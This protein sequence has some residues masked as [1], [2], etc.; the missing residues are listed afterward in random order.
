MSEINMSVIW[1]VTN[2]CP[3]NCS[4]CVM[5]AGLHCDKK[6]LSLKEKLKVCQHIDL[7]GVRV[8]LSGGE[9]M[10]VDDRKDHLILIDRLSQ[11]FGKQNIG[12]SSSGF[13]IGE[14]EAEFLASRVSDV[15]MTMDAVP[16]VDYEYRQKRYHMVAGEATIVLKR[17]GVRVGIQTV[18][19]S[20]HLKHPAI[21]ENLLQWMID[22][23]VNEWSLIRYFLSGRGNKYHNLVMS[24]DENKRVV[25][26]IKQL[27]NDT[28]N[29]PKLD[30]HYLLPGSPK[31]DRCRCVKKSI[32]ILPDG[33]VTSCFWGLDERGSIK[34]S[35]FYL[36][37]LLE[38][39]LSKILQSDTAEYW[40]NYCGRCPL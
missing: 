1:N 11:K 32:G 12:I 27:C 21:L 24:E 20:E 19:T 39:P 30:I 18:L 34:D 37:N 6:E 26:Y 40:K 7:D 3:W 31:D 15:E 4:F 17:Y 23:N 5:D 38:Y 13:G 16:E 28:E 2:K 29:A 36:G 35:R 25:E 9:V 22:N 33:S 14:K 8:D 10:N